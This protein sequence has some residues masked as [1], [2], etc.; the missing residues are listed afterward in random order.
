MEFFPL[1]LSQALSGIEDIAICLDILEQK[2][3]D[4]TVR[5]LATQY[6]HARTDLA[7]STLYTCMPVSLCIQ[8][9]AIEIIGLCRGQRSNYG[10][11]HIAILVHVVC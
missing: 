2:G 3:W 7:Y 9:T 4:L 1:S 6:L 10:L 5:S 11:Q 8:S